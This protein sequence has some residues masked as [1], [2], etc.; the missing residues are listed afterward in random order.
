MSLHKTHIIR[1]GK[2]HKP[3]QSREELE[4]GHVTG[5]STLTPAVLP[6]NKCVPIF[7]F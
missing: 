4:G 6:E 3:T 7:E 2:K 5:R 1:R